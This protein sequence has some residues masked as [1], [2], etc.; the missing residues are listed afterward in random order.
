M[1]FQKKRPKE[2]SVKKRSG[3]GVNFQKIQKI[4][5]HGREWVNKT[6]E[7]TR[8]SHKEVFKGHCKLLKPVRKVFCEM[9]F[10]KF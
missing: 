7:L 4:R 3:E 2:K 10:L 8:S 1:R 6:T 9:V 5:I